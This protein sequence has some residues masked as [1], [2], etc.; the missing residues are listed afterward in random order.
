M[1]KCARAALMLPFDS[2]VRFQ[3]R[4]SVKKSARILLQLASLRHE[5]ANLNLQEI[6]LERHHITDTLSVF[7]VL[8][9][10]S[11]LRC[12]TRFRFG[13]F[14]VSILLFLLPL[15]HILT[16]LRTFLVTALQMRFS[17]VSFKPQEVSNLQILLRRY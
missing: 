15:L 7:E 2:P 1:V 14:A 4:S 10:F 13:A 16:L 8:S 11:C 3:W 6:K 5:R 17:S 9:H 12:A